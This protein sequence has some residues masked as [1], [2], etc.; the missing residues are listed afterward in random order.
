VTDQ[1]EQ[2]KGV[3]AWFAKNHVASNLLMIL[4][5]ASGIM[6]IF[7]IK[8]EFFP[9]MSLDIITVTVPYLGASPSEVE[10]GVSLRVEEALASVDGIKRMHSTS[11]EG[12]SMVTL[13]LEEYVD[14]SEVLD[15]VKAE[16]DRIITFPVETEKPIITEIKTRYEVLTIVLHG[17]A[18][19]RTL[20]ELAENVKDDLTSLPNISQVTVAGARAYEISIEISEETLR[21][22]A[23][24]FDDVTRAVRASSMDIPGGSVKTAGG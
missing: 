18:S 5:I 23:L 24:S 17:D 11:A 7:T 9:E 21:K 3:L 16:V 19:E 1:T 20:K 8:I 6:T 12:A 22:H 13:E 2:S 14:T 4:I 15:D 10:Q